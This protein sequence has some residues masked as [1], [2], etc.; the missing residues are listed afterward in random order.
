MLQETAKHLNSASPPK[1]VERSK[2][3]MKIREV[4]SLW[5]PQSVIFLNY[6]QVIVIKKGKIGKAGGL[7]LLQD[8]TISD[9]ST[10]AL[11][12]TSCN[13]YL[14]SNHST[15]RILET[16]GLIE[17]NWSTGHTLLKYRLSNNSF[18]TPHIP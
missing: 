9:S 15:N 16:H 13:Q 6:K 18:T 3:I 12:R 5:P 4:L 8:W 1:T 7:T 17:E 14:K 10:W 2:Y 11:P